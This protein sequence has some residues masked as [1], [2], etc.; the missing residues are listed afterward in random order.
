LHIHT[1]P[2]VQVELKTRLGVGGHALVSE[3][4]TMDYYKLTSV[5]K[6]TV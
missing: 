3:F 4:S 6:C 1:S 5:L 2:L